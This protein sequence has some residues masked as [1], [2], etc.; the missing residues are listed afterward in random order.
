MTDTQVQD[1]VV[2][3]NGQ[4]YRG[5]TNTTQTT[6]DPVIGVATRRSST[7]TWSGRSSGVR[8]VGLLAVI[9]L[10][11]LALDFVFHAMGALNVGFAAF[12]FSVGS[13][14][15]SPFVGIV[16]TTQAAQGNLLVWTDVV[17]MA[18][19]AAVAILIATVVSMVIGSAA[20]RAAA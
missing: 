16:K 19:Y 10:A 20:K 14:L 3:D 17:A 8:L 5:V 12:I 15:A 13:A 2:S 7:R 9:V 1:R 6:S 11:L 18:V 4:S